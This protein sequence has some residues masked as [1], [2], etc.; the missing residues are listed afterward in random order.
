MR[1]VKVWA[2]WCQPCHTLTKVMQGMDYESVD[3]ETKE[4]MDFVAKY[5][6]RALPT[7]LILD[8]DGEVVAQKTGLMGR[9]EL[10][11]WVSTAKGEE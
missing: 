1:L 2:D 11:R 7:L 9:P 5:G 10:E 8:D 6:V 4:G 3:A